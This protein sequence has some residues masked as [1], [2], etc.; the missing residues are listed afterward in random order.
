MLRLLIVAFLVFLCSMV[1]GYTLHAGIGGDTIGYFYSAFSYG[2][3]ILFMNGYAK[4][5]QDN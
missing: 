3:M 2:F 1:G 4:D 5:F